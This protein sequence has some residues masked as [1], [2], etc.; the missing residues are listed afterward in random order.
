MSIPQIVVAGFLGLLILG[1]TL[2]MLP[3]AS[4]SGEVTPF[5]DAFFTAT[6]ALCVTGQVT[7]NTASHWSYFGKTVIITLI[8][9][10]GL[11]FMTLVVHFFFWTRKKLNIRQ[12]KV[13]QE[14]LNLD[15]IS[16]AKSI[17]RY[18]L[19]FSI[20][21]QLLGAAVLAVDLLPRYGILK[22]IYFSLFH[23]IS[24]FCNAGFDLFGPSLWE[25][26]QNP[27]ILIT[28]ASLIAIGGFGFIV[29]RD[30]LT[31]KK[32]K[33]LLLHTKLVVITTA[34]ILLVSFVLL[35]ITE[36]RNGTFAHL[37]LFDQIINTIFLAV[38]PRTAGYSNIDYN[39]V[40]LA[41]VFITYA[42]MFIGGS[43]GSTAGGIK[44]TTIAVLFLVLIGNFKGEEPN[45]KKRA[46][47]ENRVKKATNLLILA[48]ILISTAT[49]LLLVSQTLPPGF[50]LESVLMEVFS[51]F[52][53][54][55][56]T[57]GLTE[58]LNWFGKFVLM[59][60]MFIGR[61]GS[62]TVF[63][64]FGQHDKESHIHYPQGSI[65]IG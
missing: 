12:Q 48:V 50:G 25:F 28:I 49:L 58:H 16:E 8:E 60:L 63:F 46:I 33:R 55:G 52:G 24:A 11:G 36:R 29:W 45:F 32:N 5:W 37:N 14:S 27:L 40:S 3:I 1:G 47:G 38:T 23:S 41:G 21:I 39:K 18:V 15:D 30:L 42:L 10:G 61:V 35:W 57:M 6:S 64:S 62:L 59:L 20:F 7:V 34:I 9:I 51:C 44:I 2:L 54:V 17:V 19:S 56:L 26:Q 13:V 31:Y 65:L 53:T 4:Q 22:G 43:S